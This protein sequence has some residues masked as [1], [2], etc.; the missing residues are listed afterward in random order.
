MVNLPRKSGHLRDHF[1][2]T[3]VNRYRG[4]DSLPCI[5]V[6]TVEEGN[7]PR[8]VSS[9]LPGPGEVVGEQDAARRVNRGRARTVAGA[10]LERA[11][12]AQGRGRPPRGVDR[13]PES[14][15]ESMWRRR[16]WWWRC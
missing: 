14:T 10:A 8:R 9:S 6:P 16:S 4:F 12:I 7:E 3:K 11:R 13:C 1:S 15:W 5:S 2:E